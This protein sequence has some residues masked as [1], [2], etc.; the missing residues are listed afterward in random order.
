MYGY[1]KEFNIEKW[2]CYDW[3]NNIQY[4]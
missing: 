2:A 3:V 4:N 1:D